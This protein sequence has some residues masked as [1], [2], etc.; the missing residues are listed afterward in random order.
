VRVTRQQLLGQA[1]FQL[2]D[3]LGQR[4]GLG[5]EG[6]VLGGEF[7][8][9]GQVLPRAVQLANGFHDRRELGVPAAELA[10]ACLIG[11]HSRIGQL[12]LQFGIFLQQLVHD[13]P[14]FTT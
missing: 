6:V 9:R 3:A 1:P 8:G 11:V 12:T 4:L 5:G 14:S 13:S 10:R 7:P 2:R